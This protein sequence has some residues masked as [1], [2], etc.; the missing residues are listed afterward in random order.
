MISYIPHCIK[1]FIS[2]TVRALNKGSVSAKVINT[3]L[4]TYLLLDNPIF[5]NDISGGY[6]ESELL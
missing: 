1:R 3:F 5:C 2:S 6:H 4:V